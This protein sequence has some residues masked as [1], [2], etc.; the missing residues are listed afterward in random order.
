MAATTAAVVGITSALV[1]SGMSFRQ[2]AKQ[3][4]LAKEAQRA[5]AE[6]EADARKEAFTECH[7]GTSDSKRTVRTST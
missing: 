4:Q 5:Q 7:E 6:A 3:N 2:A 1:S